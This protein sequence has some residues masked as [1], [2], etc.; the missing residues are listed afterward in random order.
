MDASDVQH[1]VNVVAEFESV[2]GTFFITAY[3]QLPHQKS[4][5]ITGYIIIR[6]KI[7]QSAFQTVSLTTVIFSSGQGV[8]SN[9]EENANVL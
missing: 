1:S 3:L 6:C 8:N 2:L 9:I 4:K 5:C 7:L